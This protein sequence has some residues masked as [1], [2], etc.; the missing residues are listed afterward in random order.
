MQSIT[1]PAKRH[2]EADDSDAPRPRH[3]VRPEAGMS[4]LIHTANANAPSISRSIERIIKSIAK[5]SSAADCNVQLFA[6][7]LRVLVSL[8]VHLL[9]PA[10]QRPAKDKIAELFLAAFHKC[11]ALKRATTRPLQQRLTQ[12]KNALVHDLKDRVYE[13]V[14]TCLQRS[15]ARPD[16]E[17]LRHFVAAEG[18]DVVR[19]QFADEVE[20]AISAVPAFATCISSMVSN[21]TIVANLNPR[22]EGSIRLALA[23]TLRHMEQAPYPPQQQYAAFLRK[24]LQ[25]WELL[26][27]LSQS[28]IPATLET[29]CISPCE[30]ANPGAGRVTW[31]PRETV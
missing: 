3:R 12:E 20:S 1:S 17:K 26:V 25:A 15:L 14:G 29:V 24:H 18:V 27:S 16:E 21:P 13:S 22:N 23:K 28:I 7:F 2:R 31:K 4:S 9:F 8:V 19:T 10:E 30:G 5:A 6:V 11:Q